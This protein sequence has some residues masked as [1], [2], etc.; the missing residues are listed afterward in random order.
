MENTDLNYYLNMAYEMILE[1]APKVLLA[2]VVLIIGL[3]LAK[4]LTN[5]AR[6]GLVKR[7][8]DPSLIPFLSGIIGAVLKVMVILSVISLV[9]VPATS[10]IA[11]LGAAGLA[12]GLALSGTL[13]NF[14]G[15]VMILIIK[16]IKVGDFIEAQGHSGTVHEIQIFNTIL[17]TPNNVTVFLPNGPVSTGSITNYSTEPTRRHDWTF[18]IGYGDDA[19][20]AMAALKQL[21]EEDERIMKD[22]EPFYAVKALADS[23]VNI[24]VRCWTQSGDFWPV[25]FDMQGKVYKKFNQEGIN[26]PFPQMDVHVHNE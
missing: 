25:N 1:Y 8:M 16:P 21:V 18:G 15:G 24:A 4:K 26:I 11:V 22:P 12:I 19:D 2:I 14:A 6:K 5:T 9:G 7:N 20:K 3:W 23:S 10:F 13:Q 17:K